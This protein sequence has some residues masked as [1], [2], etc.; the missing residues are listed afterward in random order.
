MLCG[1]LPNSPFNIIWA[2]DGSGIYYTMAEKGES[3]LHFV[4][5]EGKTRKITSGVHYFSGL[6]ISKTGQAAAVVTSFHRPG[7]L[8]TFSLLRPA[9]FKTLVD[10]NADLLDGI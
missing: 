5:L 10:V 6:S 7:A 4:S 8:V 1:D 3:N 2:A 9:E